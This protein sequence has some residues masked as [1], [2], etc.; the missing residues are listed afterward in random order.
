MR[1]ILLLGAALLLVLLNG[2][3]V[4]EFAIVKVRSTKI[5]EPPGGDWRA[6][7]T[8]NASRI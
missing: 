7:V 2:F 1:E 5:K 4:A 3:F 8:R 6:S